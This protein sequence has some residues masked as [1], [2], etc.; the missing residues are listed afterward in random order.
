M[1]SYVVTNAQEKPHA[2]SRVQIN[3]AVDPEDH[4]RATLDQ[5]LAQ[6]QNEVRVPLIYHIAGSPHL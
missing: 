6:L 3:G 1:C 2:V 5:A 4:F